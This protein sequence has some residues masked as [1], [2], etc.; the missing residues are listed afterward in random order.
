M[1]EVNKVH[2]AN[3]YLGA[4]KSLIGRANE[5]SLP[6]IKATVTEHTG[7]GMVG[8]LELPSGLEVL[9]A[10]V[11][12][13]GFYADH[14]RQGANPFK[15]RQLQA[16]ANVETHGPD[17]RLEEKP[18]VWIMTAWWKKAGGGS[19]TPREAMT[20]EDELAVSFLKMKYDGQDVVE[21]DVFQNIWRVDGE[22]LLQ[23]YRE[24]IGQG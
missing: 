16:R 20:F 8:K 19:A 1:P 21:I 15:A 7:L 24:N 12:W 13:N 9:N 22:D 10:T 18:L 23:T 3:V 4:D 17:G 6:D 2:N 5:I 14:L 11:T